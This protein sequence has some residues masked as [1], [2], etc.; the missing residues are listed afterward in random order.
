MAP[1]GPV[2]GR[3]QRN[4]TWCHQVT[5]D[6]NLL[7]PR[8]VTLTV[9]PG[10]VVRFRSY[11]GYREPERRLRLRVEGRLLALGQ[12]G[13]LIRF[14]SD[15]KDPRNGD[16]SMVKLVGARG[17]RIS[18]AIFE[19]S[20]HGLNIWN[21]DISLSELVIRFNNWE[22][23]Y[24]ENHCKVQLKNSRIYGNGYNCIA[25][26]Q[27]V[28][29]RVEGSYIANCGTIGLHVD[30][31]TAVVQGSLIEGSQEGVSLD[32]DS[33]VTIAGN[34][35]TGQPNAAISCGGGRNRVRLGN[36]VFDGLPL[37]L[38]VACPAK[39]VHRFKDP[40]QPPRALA[41][42][43]QE[44][45]S[46][47][48]D[49][50]PG[51]RRR[52]PYRYVYPPVD[53]TRRVLRRV[54]RGLGLTWSVTWD[55]EA[56]WTANLDGEV[57]RLDPVSG[58]VLRRF[59]APGPQPWGMTHDGQRLWINDFARRQIAAVDPLSGKVLSSFRS[60][61][62]KGGCKGL[63]WDGE[64]LYALGWATHRLYR[65]SPQGKVERSVP[66]P[67]RDVGGGARLYVAGGLT[68]D[69]RT[70][71]APADRLVRFGRDG[72]FI[73]WLHGTSERV[74]D[75]AWDGKALW[76][77]QRAN[78]N[79]NIARLFRVKILRQQQRGWHTGAN[80]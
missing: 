31:S 68:W 78:E 14:T 65:L 36:N 60:P 3:I 61:D 49:Y 16:W 59:R 10:T 39:Q 17:S 66:V 1:Q 38:A 11:R 77:T 4:T 40:R 7:V 19:F 30:A 80:R 55:G 37:N 13:K 5:V 15:A 67:F 35:F 41:T 46:T 44:G 58:K 75:L 76:T 64:R 51:D 52:D 71:W 26:E 18:H 12:P 24:A 33:R 34:R 62:P 21:T 73:G 6:G 32:N 2:H 47:Y 56:L 9:E 69:G 70:F 22:G 8:G 42:G 43:A 53:E 74:W 50:I 27:F 72:K 20:Q 79:W 23:L 25:V 48:L 45:D 28:D 57:M 63:A 29:L 54:G